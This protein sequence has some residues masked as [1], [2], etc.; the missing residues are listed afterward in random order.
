[1]ALLRTPVRSEVLR[2]WGR[3]APSAASVLR[4][5]GADEVAKTLAGTSGAVIARGLARSYGDAAQRAGGLVL[6]CTALGGIDLDDEQGVVV[7]GAGVSIEAL[8]R[9]LVPRG[10][11]LPVLPGTRHVT[12]GGAVAADVH[13]KNHHVDGAIGRHVRWLDLVDGTGRCRRLAPDDAEPAVVQAFWATIG[14]LGLTG[15]ITTVAI[16]LR[17]IT[18]AWMTVDT[19]RVADLAT[20]MDRLRRHDRAH[21]YS[22]AWVDA[23]APGRPAGTRIGRGIVSS[24]D[25]A[26]AGHLAALGHREPTAYTTPVR[27][28]VGPAPVS[29]VRPVTARA[30]NAAWFARARRG[31]HGSLVG[32]TEFF[33]PL[34]AVRGWNR[35]YGP[36]GF[37]QYQFVVPDARE[38]LVEQALVQLG[39]AG[40]PAVL[41]VLKRFGPAD[42]APLSFPRPGWTLALDLPVAHPDRLARVLDTLDESVADAGGRVYLVKDARLRP[43]LL[44]AMYPELDAWRAVRD[45]LDPEHRFG[46][47][48][49]RRLGL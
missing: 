1:M 29:L 46:S 11:I 22:V 38:D 20:V 12:L 17:R 44:P 40:T 34:D 2:G 30:F 10:W 36:K 45:R 19:E 42:P 13:G 4:P 37:V 15:V 47:D 39:Q 14:G 16:E 23:L 31:T 49:S 21:R 5:C 25:H 3:T 7:A 26:T 24:G 35:L 9:V 32:L 18:T 27:L 33:H 48:L 28:T 8:L 43:E 6:D 41:A